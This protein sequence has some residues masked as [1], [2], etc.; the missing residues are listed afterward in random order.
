MFVPYTHS[1]GPVKLAHS[2]LKQGNPRVA[3]HYDL[4]VYLGGE[5]DYFRVSSKQSSRLRVI[6]SDEAYD[7]LERIET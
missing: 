6:I 2:S 5:V 1:Q 7:T 4:L 3:R